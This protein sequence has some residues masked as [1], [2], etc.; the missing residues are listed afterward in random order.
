MLRLN[1][2]YPYY[3]MWDMEQIVC[4]DMLSINSGTVPSHLVHPGLGMNWLMSWSTQ[5]ANYFGELSILTLED[6]RAS[7]NPMACV[8]E[9]MTFIRMHSVFAVVTIMICSWLVIK[10]FYD[11]CSWLWI[12]PCLYISTL[13]SLWFHSAHIRTE[14]YAVMFWTIAVKLTT[15]IMLGKSQSPFRLLWIGVCIGCAFLTKIQTVILISMPIYICICSQIRYKSDHGDRN[16]WSLYVSRFNFLLYACLYVYVSQIEVSSLGYHYAYIGELRSPIGIGFFGLVFLLWS[17]Q[18]LWRKKSAVLDPV[19]KCLNILILGTMA[20]F[21]LHFFFPLSIESAWGYLLADFK[22]S[23]I[24]PIVSL[25]ENKFLKLFQLSQYLTLELLLLVL[26]GGILL[27]RM[28]KLQD[29]KLKIFMLLIFLSICVMHVIFVI[30]IQMNDLLFVEVLLALM[31]V[32]LV[33]YEIRNNP[34]PFMKLVAVGTFAILIVANFKDL[35]YL[36]TKID[37]CYPV[38]GFNHERWMHR[39]YD[40]SHIQYE[41]I[42]KDRLGDSFGEAAKL[43]RESS[44]DWKKNLEWVSYVFYNL[45]IDMRSIGI[46]GDNVPVFRNHVDARLKTYPADIKGEVLVDLVGHRYKNIILNRQS[47]ERRFTYF[48]HISQQPQDSMGVLYRRDL[49]IYIFSSKRISETIYGL[50]RIKKNCS[51]VVGGA[52]KLFYGYEVHRL[53]E[54]PVELLGEYCFAVLKRDDSPKGKDG[55]PVVRE[56]VL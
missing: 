30:R 2:S 47:I 17:I 24:R 38:Y 29:C 42:M 48:K 36:K 43:S 16:R 14:L 7:L 46:V 33:A 3:Y 8:A 13:E 52:E 11:R 44:L 20:S 1:E 50:K 26:W 45:N 34:K 25:S 54:I 31:L 55:Y 9:Y 35:S 5:I 27:W 21:L 22:A 32:V 15:P 37:A 10:D 12:L 41:T 19:F 28:R 49:K 4:L 40:G 18:D 51:V 6:L 23:L 39:I 53:C 56:P